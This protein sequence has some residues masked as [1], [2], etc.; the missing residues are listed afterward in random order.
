MFLERS[1]PV[2]KIVSAQDA[3]TILM[4]GFALSKW[5]HIQTKN[6]ILGYDPLSADPMHESGDPALKHQ[7]FQPTFR[8]KDDTRFDLYP[9]IKAIEDKR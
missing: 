6:V 8:L 7:I 1:W 4:V 5:P 9:F 3:Y 2:V